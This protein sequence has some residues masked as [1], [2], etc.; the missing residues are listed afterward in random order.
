MFVDW[1]NQYCQND[2]TTQGNLQI[3]HNPYQITNGIFHRTRTKKLKFVWNHKRSLIA[4]AIM[5]KKGKTEGFMLYDFKLYFKAMIIKTVW[6][7]HKD[8]HIAQWKE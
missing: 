6:Y 7:W 5:K 8:K 2:Y 4:K 1:K 3:L